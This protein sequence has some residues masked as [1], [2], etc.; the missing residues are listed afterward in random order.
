MHWGFLLSASRDW[1]AC[2]S[3][4]TS[5]A[6][7]VPSRYSFRWAMSS[8]VVATWR[9][10]HANTIASAGSWMYA[11]TGGKCRREILRFEN[12]R[13]SITPKD[14]ALA[15]RWPTT[16]THAYEFQTTPFFPYDACGSS[17][18][19]ANYLQNKTRRLALLRE[20]NNSVSG[21]SSSRFS[22]RRVLR[23][24]SVVDFNRQ[25]ASNAYLRPFVDLRRL[26]MYS[27]VLVVLNI[28]LRANILPQCN[29]LTLARY[30][31]QAI[32]S[33]D[34]TTCRTT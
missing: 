4:T 19:I 34:R 22:P 8:C 27:F 2:D 32:P 20:C 13:A 6:R 15:R 14:A 17:L 30:S 12:C 9:N 23:F 21:V 11:D 3:K 18:V 10:I 1:E 28:S 16:Y 29:P 26:F 25:P 31:I 24:S 33:H 7:R 5:S